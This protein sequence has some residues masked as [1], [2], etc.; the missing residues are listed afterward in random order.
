V[1][2]DDF[3]GGDSLPPAVRQQ[4]FASV[5]RNQL[6]LGPFSEDWLRELEEARLQE[7]LQ[8]AGYF[9][10]VVRAEGQVRRSDAAGQHVAIVVHIDEGPRYHLAS[11]QFRSTSDSPPLFNPATLREQVPLSDGAFFDVSKIRSG[12]EALTS[13]HGARGYIDFTAVP[14]TQID[15]KSGAINLIILLNPEKAYRIGK[16]EVWSDDPTSEEFLHAQWKV[17]EIFN[18]TQVS[19]FLSKNKAVLPEDASDRDLE[20]HRNV[21]EGTVDLRFDFCCACPSSQTK[22]AH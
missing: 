12:L 19:A 18:R 22:L 13:L 9:R 2:S 7:D 1:D 20:I 3:V 17:G 21:K 4:V 8:E 6:P 11:V 16:V 15:E 5:Q 10:A 14:E